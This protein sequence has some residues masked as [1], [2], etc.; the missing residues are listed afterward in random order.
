MSLGAERNSRKVSLRALMK[1]PQTIPEENNR[2]AAGVVLVQSGSKT[3]RR[4][5]VCAAPDR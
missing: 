2:F 1:R 5:G 4:S 3:W